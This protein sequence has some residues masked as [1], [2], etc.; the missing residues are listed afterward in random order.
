VKQDLLRYWPDEEAVRACIKTDAEA[1]S[2]AVAL[3]V[4]QPMRLERRTIGGAGGTENCSEHDLLRAFL[5]EDLSEG[6]AIVPIVGSSGVGKSHVIRW[7]DA[8]I[9]GAP[10]ADRRVVIRI[11][12]GTSLRGVLGI[13]LSNVAGAAYEDYRR[14]LARAQQELDPNEAAGLLCEM[15]AHTLAER[16]ERARARLA[17]NPADADAKE[18]VAFCSTDMLPALLR[19]Q[20]LRDHH[21]LRRPDGSDGVARRLVAQFTEVR[22]TDADDDRQFVPSDLDFSGVERDVLGRAE[23]TALSRLREDRRPLAAKILNSALDD[24][25]QRLLRLDPTVSELFSRVREQLLQ[26]G[27]ELVLLVEDFADLSGLQKQLLQIVIKEAVRDGRQYLCTMRT[28]LAYTTGYLDA[29]TFFTRANVE[30][31]IPNEP[32]TEEEILKKI[33]KLVGAYLNAARI[34][35]SQLESEYRGRAGDAWVPTFSA[36]V[37]P[38]SQQTLSAFGVTEDDYSLFPFNRAAVEEL[39]RE[40][41]VQDGRL[42]YNPRFVIQNVIKKVLSNRTLFEAGT[43]PPATFGV[44]SVPAKITE[45]VRKRVPTSELDRYLRFIAYWGGLPS[46]MIELG[47]TPDRVFGAFGLNGLLLR[48]KSTG[49]VPTP[50]SGPA[51][52]VVPRPKQTPTRGHDV[53][54]NPLEAHWVEQLE[55]WRKGIDLPQKDAN[56]L[57]KWIA[58]AMKASIDWDWVLHR[59]ADSVT[60]RDEWS[61]YWFKYV[62][63]PSAGG[64][65]GRGPDDSMIAVCEQSHLSDEIRSARVVSTLM[66]IV[67][68]HAVHKSWEYE[69]ADEDIPAYCAFLDAHVPVAREF[70]RQRYFRSAWDPVPTL[71]S[72][73]L[74]GARALAIPGSEKDADEALFDAIFRPCDAAVAAIEDEAGWEEY[75]TALRKCRRA[76]PSGDKETPETL[77]WTTHLLNVVGARQ[78]GGDAVHAVDV[79]ALRAA[80]HATKSQWVVSGTIPSPAG[81]AALPSLKAL[82][83]EI[84][85]AGSSVEKARS[86]IVEWRLQTVEWFGDAAIDKDTLVREMKEVIESSKSAGL[87]RGIDGSAMK[88]LSQAVEAF[89]MAPVMSALHETEHLRPDAAPGVVLTVLGR[90]NENA[91]AA[92][93]E[94]RTRFEELLKAVADELVSQG[95]F[96]GA[97]PLA[98]AT[99]ALEGEVSALVDVLKELQ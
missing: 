17:E 5:T 77:S 87:V 18:C 24:A 29:A 37:E 67:R 2:E 46:A 91:V 22:E 78:G 31:H 68:F 90:L 50:S 27:K 54:L 95:Q 43:F 39:A 94:V 73:L 63:I 99:S 74:V 10:G 23:Q 9:R 4:H 98:E 60:K 65:E 11:P 7:L 71:V 93:N 49:P 69:G 64:S 12:K 85:R 44:R 21:F 20:Y 79:V 96:I 86:R 88:R 47:N 80:V 14:E 25:K 55:R 15:L 42:V 36:N 97:D 59:T 56:D 53:S 81:V 72:G 92:C 38:E 75:R 40:G 26:E 82:H 70:V 6:R 32:G 41:C 8:H 84:R 45:E 61:G 35:Q 58:E 1:S 13:L 83:S 16:A 89:R 51:S 52:T 3:A 28:A 33:V 19:N 66:A 76:S 34:G 30:F 62:Y 48:G 57:R